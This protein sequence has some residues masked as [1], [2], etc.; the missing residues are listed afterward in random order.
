MEEAGPCA[1]EHV[2]WL[3]KGGKRK[4]SKSFDFILRI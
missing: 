4:M 2:P 3:L 1:D